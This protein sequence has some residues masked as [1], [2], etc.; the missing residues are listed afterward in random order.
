M[1]NVE[2]LL[3]AALSALCDTTA[4]REALGCKEESVGVTERHRS[5]DSIAL[6]N[7][8]EVV[9]MLDGSDDG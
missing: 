9:A 6:E 3:E 7:L 8:N 4:L 1:A 5:A 2:Y